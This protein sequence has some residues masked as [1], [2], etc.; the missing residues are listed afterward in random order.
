MTKVSTGMQAKVV[1]LEDG[2]RSESTGSGSATNA[3]AVNDSQGSKHQSKQL[4]SGNT[5]VTFPSVA[6][7]GLI[8]PP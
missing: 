8:C 5:E 3:I 2:V 4:Q 7:Y 6:R 1:V